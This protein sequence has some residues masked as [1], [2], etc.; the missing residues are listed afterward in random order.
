M[1]CFFVILVIYYSLQRKFK[2]Q[3]KL[4]A[5]GAIFITHEKSYNS[6]FRFSAYSNRRKRPKRLLFASRRRL[7]LWMLRWYG[8]VR[9]L[10]AI[11][12]A[13]Q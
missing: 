5:G 9:H 12:S 8:F 3:F 4:S 7:R 1:A 13:M 11:L 6:A 2:T 10:R